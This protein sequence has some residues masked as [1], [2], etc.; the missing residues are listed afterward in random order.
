M[1]RK[2]LLTRLT[3]LIFFIFFINL[4]AMKLYWYYA[5]WY[6]D[7]PMHFLGGVWAAMVLLWLLPSKNLTPKLVF[8]VVLG[9]ILIG[10]AW[11][12]FEFMLDKSIVHNSFNLLDT[13]SDFCF[14]LAGALAYLV[15]NFRKTTP[16]KVNTL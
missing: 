13:L 5:I 1:D 12:V 2:K 8:Q 6:F 3:Y 15:F 14:D 11:E 4:V 16:N 7:M 10:T 9:V